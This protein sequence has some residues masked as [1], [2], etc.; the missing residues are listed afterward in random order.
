MSYIYSIEPSN[1]L[2]LKQERDN[3]ITLNL[4]YRMI[5]QGNV[6]KITTDRYSEIL[7]DQPPGV[8]ILQW[9]LAII[10]NMANIDN[11]IE[12][13]KQATMSGKRKYYTGKPCKYGHFALRYTSNG[14]CTKCHSKHM[15]NY[16][17][18]VKI[19]GIKELNSIIK[20][21]PEI[22]QAMLN[23]AKLL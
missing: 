1:Y 6:K 5:P 18:K 9:L 12:T 19:P 10:F 3:N 8:E 7:Q 4:F 17:N 15:S 11:T 13:R 14:I 20:A 23:Y 16:N 2:I 22:L 21:K